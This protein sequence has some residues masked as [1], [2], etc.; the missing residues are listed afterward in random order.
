MGP[1]DASSGNVR[2]LRRVR[3]LIAARDRRFV[4]AATFVLTRR[5][6]LVDSAKAGDVLAT[7]E[8]TA[9]DVVVLDGSD[10]L[11][12]AGRIAAAVE[13]EYP[14]T[15]VVLV[16]ENHHHATSTLPKWKAFARLIEEIEGLYGIPP[17][18]RKA[19]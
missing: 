1:A 13:G 3:V 12:S 16:S 19:I 17:S 8:R 18:A 9:P 6:F 2:A 10:A 14:G 7:V 4:T 5:G 15:S 11:A